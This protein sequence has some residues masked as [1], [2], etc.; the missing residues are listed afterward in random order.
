MTRFLRSHAGALGLVVALVSAAPAA[1]QSGPPPAIDVGVAYQFLQVPDADQS[2]P[3]G[4]NVDLTGALPLGLRWVG[5]VGLS[6]DRE[7]D[8]DVGV[9]STLTALHYAAGLRVSPGG[10]RW[11]YAQVLIGRHR[12]GFTVSA[13]DIGEIISESL[14]TTML[15]PG[16]GIAFNVGRWRIFG[17]AD[18]RRIMY[19]GRSEHDYRALAG[20]R[21]GLR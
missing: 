10:G 13:D 5:E 2:Y 7:R 11:P 6:R 18:Y 4:A 8:D 9:T 15:Q 19:E 17:Q 20:V 12:D 1:A 3:L 16:A 14:T 21:F